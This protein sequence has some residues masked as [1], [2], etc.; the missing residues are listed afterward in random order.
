M[1]YSQTFPP[2]MFEDLDFF[3]FNADTPSEAD[4]NMGDFTFANPPEEYDEDL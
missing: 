4:Q 1:K 3:A 2:L